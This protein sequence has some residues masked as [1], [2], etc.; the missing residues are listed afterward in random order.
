[1]TDTDTGVR[2][3]ECTD[4]LELY[5]RFDGQSEA[6]DAYIALD[7]D[8]ASLCASYN[9]EVGN[10][11]PSEVRYGFERRYNIPILTGD[12]ANRAMQKIRPMAE[13]IVADWEREWNGN[14]H[15]AVLGE[16]AQAAEEEI[17]ELLGLNL[18][19]GATDADTQGFDD[20]DIVAVWD[21]DGA[22]SGDEAGEYGITADTTDARLE[23]IAD[24]ITREMAACADVPPDDDRT[25]VAVVHGLEEYLRELRNELAEDDPLTSAELRAAREY[26]GL[27]DTRLAKRLR[28]NL[29]TLRGWEQDRDPI[30]GHIRPEIAEL[31][32]ATDAAVAK[33]VAG[34]AD[35]G[36]NTL[37]TYRNDDEYRAAV[38][39][40]AWSQGWHDWSA[41]W[42]RRVC[43]RAAAQSGARIEYA[44][45]L[46]E[47]QA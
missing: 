40:T 16:D 11:I 31:K 39:G 47:S 13:R 25:P 1:M 18:G 6:Q 21:T 27:D 4:P 9:S 46:E 33:L 34:L 43:A 7:L 2:I 8:N 38:R 24:E 22:T 5:R 20:L 41:S 19:Y 35:R 10:A 15:V 12:A 29:C 36:D 14:N 17:E 28:V 23:Q 45:D 32:E 37:I 3:I 42:H 44:E 30:P 26:L